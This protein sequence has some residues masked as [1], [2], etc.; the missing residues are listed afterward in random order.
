MRKHKRPIQ[1]P[2][3]FDAGKRG[4][5]KAYLFEFQEQGAEKSRTMTIA[6]AKLEDAVSYLRRDSPDFQIKSIQNLGLI[7]MVSGSPLD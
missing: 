2:C 5:C 4:D 3:R 6:A 7:I 1:A